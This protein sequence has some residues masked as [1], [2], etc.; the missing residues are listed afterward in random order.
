MAK[1]NVFKNLLPYNFEGQVTMFKN[2]PTQADLVVKDQRGGDT[3]LNYNLKFDDMKRAIKTS[4]S[5]DSDF[6]SFESELYIQSLVDWAYNIK[7]LS[8]RPDLKE[9]MLS[10][11]LTPLSKTEYESSFEMMTPWAQYLLDKV[12]VSSVLK[13]NANEGDFKLAYEI[14]SLAG[15]GGCS[16]KW[17]Q[18]T[19]FQD[20]QLKLFNEK[21]DKSRTFVTQ[22][23]LTNSANLPSDLVFNVDIN[24]IWTLSSKGE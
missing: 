7:I 2:M 18:K 17:L 12:N 15:S 11:T 1:G 8:S 19:S 24:S 6:I 23:G 4:V 5:R 9:V 3:T 21:K 10:T 13:T 16:W 20:Y 14:S 22:V